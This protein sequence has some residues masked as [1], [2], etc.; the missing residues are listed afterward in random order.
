MNPHAIPPRWDTSPLRTRSGCAGSKRQPHF[1]RIVAFGV[2]VAEPTLAVSIHGACHTLPVSTQRQYG[3]FDWQPSRSPRLWQDD[4]PG[5]PVSPVPTIYGARMAYV[6]PM[7]RLALTIG[8][9]SHAAG[10]RDIRSAGMRALSGHGSSTL[11]RPHSRARDHASTVTPCAWA[12]AV[13]GDSLR[14]VVRC[15]PDCPAAMGSLWGKAA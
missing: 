1:T 8:G 6:G 2:P 11:T 7:A 13:C 14:P 4:S 3:C 15:P 12:A 5:C 9:L 10:L